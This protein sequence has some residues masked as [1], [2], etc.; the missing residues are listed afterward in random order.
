MVRVRVVVPDRS[1][2]GVPGF[3]AAQQLWPNG[4]S[5]GVIPE[6]K[7]QELRDAKGMLALVGEPQPVSDTEGKAPEPVQQKQASTP[8]VSSA[9]D[10]EDRHST[11][12]ARKLTR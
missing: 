2:Q 12:P 9:A 4:E 11:G 3:Y 8:A 5:E 7:V 10:T 1:A 6:S